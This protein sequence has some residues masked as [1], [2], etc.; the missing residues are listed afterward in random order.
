MNVLDCKLT[1][2]G[3]S[4]ND[5]EKRSFLNKYEKLIDNVN[6]KKIYRGENKSTL[7]DLY[8][9]SDFTSFSHSLFLI[10]N[11]GRGLIND[12]AKRAKDKKKWKLDDVQKA[13]FKTLFEII[14]IIMNESYPVVC[15]FSIHNK[16][17]FDYFKDLNNLDTFVNA[18]ARLKKED[19]IKIRDYYLKLAHQFADEH[20]YPISSLLSV[21]TDFNVADKKFSG[22]GEEKIVLFGWL[23]LNKNNNYEITFDYLNLA[24]QNLL[25]NNLPIYYHSFYSDENEISL[26]GGLL[27]HFLVGFLYVDRDSDINFDINPNFLDVKS[28]SQLWINEGLPI[29]QSGFWNELKKTN[30]QGSFWVNYKGEY[31]NKYKKE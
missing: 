8:H 31:W 13:V 28:E 14:N 5:D 4:L 23:P 7:F 21:T 15:K 30:F 22:T 3:S 9:S 1:L 24:E 10:G 20:F 18:I 6:C 26:K 19:R 11:K 17:L 29:N 2:N 12:A 25:E 16:N 27:P